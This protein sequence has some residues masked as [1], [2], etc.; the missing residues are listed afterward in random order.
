MTFSSLVQCSLFPV[1]I[2]LV[3]IEIITTKNHDRLLAVKYLFRGDVF[4]TLMKISLSQ[5]Q[6]FFI[7]SIV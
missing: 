7:L 6:D 3:I 4:E 2:F 5:F 1:S